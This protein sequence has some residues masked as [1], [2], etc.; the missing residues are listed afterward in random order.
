MWVCLWFIN[1][2]ICVVVKITT[3][4]QKKKKNIV[5]NC[6]LDYMQ[7]IHEQLIKNNPMETR[8][9]IDIQR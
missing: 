9:K 5:K 3:K 2:N 7:D 4:E 6:L 8:K 1:E